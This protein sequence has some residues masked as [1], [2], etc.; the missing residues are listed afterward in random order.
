MV[1][2]SQF[3][4]GYQQSFRI[5]AEATLD[6]SLEGIGA[7]ALRPRISVIGFKRDGSGPFP[8]CVEPEAG[9]LQPMHLA[10]VPSQ[11][12]TLIAGDPESDMLHTHPIAHQLHQERLRQRGW[13][14][15]IVDAVD[16]S[17]IYPR[18]THFCSLG[19]ELAGF[20]V[21]V[22]AGVEQ[23]TYNR[24]PHLE[25]GVVDRMRVAR[26]L[27][28]EVIEET[29]AAA[30][31]ALH[32]PDPGPGG[33]G[34]DDVDIIRSSASYF[35]RCCAAKAGNLFAEIYGPLEAATSQKYEGVGAA[36]HL[37]LAQ[38][39]H[40]AVTELLRFGRAVS[41]RRSRAVRKFL[42]MTDGEVE[43]LTDGGAIY[44]LVQYEQ[45][46]YDLMTE[47]LFEI[48][49]P[50]HAT[51]ELIH[52]GT[53]LMRVS[54][55]KASLPAPLVDRRKYDDTMER[56]FSRVPELDV[57]AI[58]RLVEA[59][60]AASHG[61]MLVISSAASSEAVRLS[62]QATC[63]QPAT[64][65]N[66]LMRRISSIDGAVLVDCAGTCHAIGVILDGVATNRGDPARGA[67]Y[68]SAIRYLAGRAGETVIIIVSEDGTVNLV[69]ELRPRIHRSRVDDALTLL[70]SVSG[71]DA[72]RETFNRAWEEVEALEFY[73]DQAQC[74]EANGLRD[75]LE[76]AS[77]AA[78]HIKIIFD[79]LAPSAEMNE[80]YF[81]V[82]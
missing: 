9:R 44:G 45:S 33:I 21:F 17:G 69:P 12:A 63:V 59:A 34:R 81:L 49:V 67:R 48:R 51:W 80:S 57:D 50:A 65:D 6:R 3:M 54:Y 71:P 52:G 10:Q 74:D 70:Q 39:G 35:A 46:K 68:N 13:R 38:P 56:V 58:W 32:L 15:A 23:D 62:G 47:D 79:R 53:T 36:G 73:L 55:G 8:I 31:T 26:S 18:R 5:V 72:D 14:R 64:I 76:E 27:A 60:M 28:E 1:T 41:L 43:L 42:E 22:L 7:S 78:G 19:V 75:V 77:L 16:R 25:I 66:A 61:T 37:I 40:S 24:I 29:L 11:A 82:D 4:W 20:E 2:I 30:A